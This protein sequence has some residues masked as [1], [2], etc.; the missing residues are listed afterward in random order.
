MKKSRLTP[1]KCC[2]YLGFVLDTERCLLI[3]TEKKKVNLINKLESFLILESCSIKKFAQLLGKLVAACPAMKYGWL[4]TKLLEYEKIKALEKSLGNYKTKMIVSKE[5]KSD[6]RWWILNIPN[7]NKSFKIESYVKVIYTDASDTGW[8]A[9]DGTKNI[10]G[11]W[12]KVDIK[13]HINYKELLAVY[14]A[15]KEIANNLENCNLVL[16]IDNTAIAYINRMFGV[17]I[18]KFN[19]LASLIWQWA[20]AKNISL[21]A[22]YI[23]SKENMNADRLSR[24]LNTQNGNWVTNI[25]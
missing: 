4:Y 17:R 24:I 22:A 12:N 3:L 1:S 13:L 14:L 10:F 5:I 15:L 18:Q 9:T 16:R 23:P 25:L 11:F 6:I 20:E 21:R 19:K 8:G 2:K 7:G